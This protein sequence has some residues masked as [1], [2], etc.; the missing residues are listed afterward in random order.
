M[1]KTLLGNIYKSSI[2]RVSQGDNQRHIKRL[3]TAGSS[4][5]RFKTFNQ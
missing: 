1:S 2:E 5:L 4:L 3:E